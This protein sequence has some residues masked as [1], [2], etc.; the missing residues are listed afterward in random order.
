MKHGLKKNAPPCQYTLEELK[1]RL[2]Q[3]VIDAKNGRGISQ[4]DMKKMHPKLRK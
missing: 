1:E 4:E 3:G 2:A